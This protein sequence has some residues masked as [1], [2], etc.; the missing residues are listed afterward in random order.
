MKR[1]NDNR[2]AKTSLSNRRNSFSTKRLPN[3]VYV[4]KNG[5]IYKNGLDGWQQRKNGKW[6]SNRIKR[7]SYAKK[8]QLA[9][10][11]QLKR[12]SVK[13]AKKR[14]PAYRPKKQNHNRDLRRS[15]HSRQRGNYR[16]ARRRNYSRSRSR[17]HS[18]SPRRSSGGARRSGGGRR[19]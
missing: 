16:H 3:N 12:P 5:K 6:Q 18:R 1:V 4:G 17:S 19:R 8:A 10:R 11:K 2:I 15:Y 14:M 13:P 9:N 7:P